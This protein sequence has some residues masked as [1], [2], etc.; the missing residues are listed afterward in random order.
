MAANWARLYG[1]AGQHRPDAQ[2]SELHGLALLSWSIYP[3]HALQLSW[4]L[5]ARSYSSV[6]QSP[7][8]GDPDE[9]FRHTVAALALTSSKQFVVVLGD[10]ES[11]VHEDT[12]TM[13]GLGRIAIHGQ[14]VAALNAAH[15]EFAENTGGKLTLRLRPGQTLKVDSEAFDEITHPFGFGM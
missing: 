9:R 6:A 14:A 7:F 3:D 8:R 5:F 15:A 11:I 12:D 4:L 1:Q 10:M 2:V 13:Q